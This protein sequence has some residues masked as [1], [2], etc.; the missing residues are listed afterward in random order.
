METAAPPLE[1]LSLDT[2]VKVDQKLQRTF[3]QQV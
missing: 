2:L 1:I 3:E